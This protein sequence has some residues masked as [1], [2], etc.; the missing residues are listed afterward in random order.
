MKNRRWLSIVMAMLLVV[1][2][3]ACGGSNNAG[4]SGGST[5][6][7]SGGNTASAGNKTETGKT[8]TKTDTAQPA[9]PQ[10]GDDAGAGAAFGTWEEILSRDYSKPITI[11]YAGVQLT[12]GVDF[13]HGS[14]YTSWWSDTFNVE[15][16]ATVLTF[17]NWT[18]RMNTWINADDL[19]DWSVWNFNAGDAIN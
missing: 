2:L 12:E 5:A 10:G 14:E 18:Q 17:E 19:P 13:N 3:A 8:E 16:D 11:E 6:A 7:P 1:S 15:W 4:N 9:E